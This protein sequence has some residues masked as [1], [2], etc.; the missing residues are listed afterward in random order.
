MKDY[1]LVG[2]LNL[3]NTVPDFVT[4]VYEKDNTYYFASG[5]YS[6]LK[7]KK[8]DQITQR[9]VIKKITFLKD[10]HVNSSEFNNVAINSQPFFAFQYSDDSVY[11]GS[12][13]EMQKFLRRFKTSNDELKKDI[14]E[15]LSKNAN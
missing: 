1:K 6:D 11:I 12:L 3:F 13:Y 7:L 2:Y 5:T 9:D 4:P 8:F 14:K 15:F 10:I